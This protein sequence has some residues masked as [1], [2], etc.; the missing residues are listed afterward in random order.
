VYVALT[1]LLSLTGAVLG[2]FGLLFT[3]LYAGSIPVPLGI[4]VTLL[5]LPWLVRAS[6]ELDPRPLA[7]AGPLIGWVVA[8]FGLAMFG[9]GGDHMLPLTWQ[10]LLFVVVG[11]G[12]GLWALRAVL[13]EENGPPYEPPAQGPSAGADDRG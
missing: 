5:S 8:V 12:S 11:L 10:S 2:A 1:A 7:A 4:V 3:P 6:G 9:P 13:L